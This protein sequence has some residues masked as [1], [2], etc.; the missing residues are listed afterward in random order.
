[1]SIV[2]HICNICSSNKGGYICHCGEMRCIC[3]RDECGNCAQQREFEE[4]QRMHDEE[5]RERADFEDRM[6]EKY[7][8]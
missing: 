7:N 3:E 6:E 5:E 8:R 1:M 4:E 2:N